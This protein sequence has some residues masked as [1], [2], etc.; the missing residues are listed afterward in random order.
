LVFA[1]CQQHAPILDSGRVKAKSSKLYLL[2]FSLQSPEQEISLST[3]AKKTKIVLIVVVVFVG[4]LAAAFYAFNRSAV[5]LPAFLV[6]KAVSGKAH[7]GQYADING[8]RIYYETYGTGRPVLVV[9]GGT[10]AIELMHYQISALAASRF[11]IA[12]DSRAHGRSSDSNQPL[13]YDLMANDMLKLLDKLN[14]AETDVVGWSDGGIIGLDLAMQQPERVKRL[15][16]FG[17]NYDVDGI[18]TDR[19]PIPPAEKD[20]AP[21]RDFYKHIA[22]DPAHW[23]VLYQKITE[24]WRTQP[25]YSLADLG[26]IKAQTLIMAGEFDCIKRQHTDQLAKAIPG[27]NEEIIKGATHEAPLFQPDGVNAYILKFLQ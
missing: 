20:I 4:A 15:V 3:M 13:S 27:A 22:P 17:A 24:M 1:V 12:P 21:A 19:C 9:H 7:G 16:V 8:I 25:R 10:G 2:W 14:I 18:D 23:P 11:V 5:G 6:W 26:T